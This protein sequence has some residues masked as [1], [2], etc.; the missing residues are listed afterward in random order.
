MASTNF[1]A[2]LRAINVG[3]GRRVQMAELRTL[4][5]DAGATAVQT[6]I[7]SGNVV[8]DHEET[9]EAALSADL[10]T[11][12][13]AAFGFE[14]PVILRR[15]DE[16]GA[17]VAG[18]PFPHAEH[19]RLLVSLLREDPP[20]GA[21]GAIDGASFA[22]EEFVLSGRDVYLHLPDGF[23]RAKLPSAL[24]RTLPASG[25]ARNWR[26]VLALLDMARSR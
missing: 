8:F 10:E 6:Y 21:L 16:W 25:T 12:L 19:D 17:L 2:L 3:T 15:A 24:A 26:T 9:G 14:I 5:A 20:A 4:M 1:I 13:Q 18:N 7:Q 11:R 22:P 23:G